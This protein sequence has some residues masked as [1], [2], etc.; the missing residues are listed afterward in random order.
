MRPPSSHT[1][2]RTYR[3]RRFLLTLQLRVPLAQTDQP[4][5]LEPCRRHALLRRGAAAQAPPSFA[6]QGPDLHRVARSDALAS[7]VPRMPLRHWVRW[8]EPIPFVRVDG[9]EFGFPV[10]AGPRELSRTNRRLQSWTGH[11]RKMPKVSLWPSGLSPSRFRDG[12]VANN[13]ATLD[14][15]SC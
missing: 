7:P 13:S 4:E 3:I 2:G 8:F 12:F 9:R 11:S 6:A 5:R 14:S 15:S 1:T 10:Y